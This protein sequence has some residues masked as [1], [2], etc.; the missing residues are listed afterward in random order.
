[1]PCGISPDSKYFVDVY[2][3]HDT[4]PATR[5]VDAASGKVVAEIAQERHRRSSTELGLKKAEMFTYKAADGRTTLHGL[6]QF[7]STF[8][9][10]E[11]YPAL[12]Q[13]LRRPGVG[14]QHRARDVRH[15]ERADRVRLPR[16]ATSTRARRPAWASGC[17][18]RST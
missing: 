6:M 18:T 11:E 12:V 13:R 5:L 2:Q 15:A 7:P 3:T 17:S 9:P 16:A 8:D 10:R 1:M 4:P 14:E